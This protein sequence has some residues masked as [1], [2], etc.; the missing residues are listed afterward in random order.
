MS[1]IQIG[2]EAISRFAQASMPTSAARH[3]ARPRARPLQAPGPARRHRARR[4]RR[5]PWGPVDIVVEGGQITEIR[6]V[7]TPGVRSSPPAA[8]AAG[9]HEI[10]CQGK[11]VTPG[12]IDCHGHVGVAYH[13]QRSARSRRPTTST[14]SGSPMASPPC[15]KPA[16]S[17]G[18]PA[19]STRSSA[20]AEGE[21]AAPNMVVHSYF[22]AVPDVMKTIFIAR[23]GAGLGARHQGQGRRRHQV[24]R[25][26]AE[27][28]GGRARRGE[29]RGAAHL[30]PSRPAR[31]EPDERADHGASWGLTSAEHYYGLPE[32]LFEKTTIQNFPDHYN[33]GDEY[34]RFSTAGQMFQQAAEPGGRRSGTTRSTRSSKS[35]SPSCRPSTSTRPTATSCVRAAPTGTRATRTTRCGSSTSRPAAPTARTGPRW[36][37]QNELDWKTRYRIW[38]Q[39]INDYKNRGGRVCTGSN[40]GFIFQLYGFGLMREFELLQE[41]GLPSAGGAAR[42]RRRT[43]PTCSGLGDVTGTLEVGK[44][45]DI[46]VHDR[47]PARR[48]QDALRHRRD[49]DEREHRRGGVDA[50]PVDDDQG[51][52]GVRHAPAAGGCRGDGREASKQGA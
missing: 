17:T 33:Y 5:P 22:P 12:F 9:D 20:P 35:A 39:F 14:S 8:P 47:E 10:D 31:G 25:R 7:G 44:R 26:A 6:R 38:M 48:L 11:Y 19:R 21:I 27:H 40:S 15:A 34:H 52:H 51:R 1:G 24:L 41:A 30:L 3:H 37:T 42:A 49:A 50:L 29:N 4:H 2:E 32:A 43:A 28:H 18:W 13:R 36:T 16:A 45:A 23:P 46:L